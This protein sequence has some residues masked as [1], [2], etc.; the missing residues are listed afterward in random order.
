MENKPDEAKAEELKK[1]RTAGRQAYRT[2]GSACAPDDWSV[3]A[4]RAYR[5]AWGAALL[6]DHGVERKTKKPAPPE[7]AESTA[8]GAVRQLRAT[9]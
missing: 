3:E 2:N 6:D 7:R 8:Q 4:Q 1:A 5:R 9:G